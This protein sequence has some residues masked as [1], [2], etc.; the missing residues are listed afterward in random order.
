LWKGV[1]DG[2]PRQHKHA[3][4]RW[5]HR[6]VEHSASLFQPRRRGRTRCVLASIGGVTTGIHYR[7]RLI[8]T[9]VFFIAI[10]VSGVILYRLGRSAREAVPRPRG[11]CPR[12]RSISNSGGPGATAMCRM[13]SP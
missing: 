9:D 12:R 1:Q 13:L 10:A 11:S 7:I 5:R 2:G 8:V 6:W 3:A 4:A